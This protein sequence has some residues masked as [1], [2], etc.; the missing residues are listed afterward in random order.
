MHQMSIA[1]GERLINENGFSLLANKIQVTIER[2][3]QN[4]KLHQFLRALFSRHELM[5]PSAE[6]C[7]YL[8]LLFDELGESIAA[9]GKDGL[10]IAIFKVLLRYNFNHERVCRYYITE[11]DRY[12]VENPGKEEAFLETVLRYCNAL[13]RKDMAYNELGHR[14]REEIG[15]HTRLRL[16]QTS[17]FQPFRLQLHANTF[18]PLMGLLMKSEVFA[19]MEPAVAWDSLRHAFRDS[20]GDCFSLNT[21]KHR[22]RIDSESKLEDLKELL[23]K[24]NDL[25]EHH[26]KLRMRPVRDR[27]RI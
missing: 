8:H 17:S 11:I 16:E 26:I 5:F 18:Y 21:I 6:Q 3:K 19:E 22:F 12:I 10:E 9:P 25:V 24:L 7:R 2:T 1:G 13:D 4:E 27:N 23:Q 15:H 20:K 14:L